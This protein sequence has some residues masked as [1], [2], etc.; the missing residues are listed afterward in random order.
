MKG[1]VLA[2]DLGERRI[3]LAV[4]DP[5]RLVARPL[6]TLARRDL[7]ADVAAIRRVAADEEVAEVVEFLDSL[8]RKVEEKKPEEKKPEEKKPEEKKPPA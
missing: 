2:L 6:L 8:D 3:G 4:S 5:L 1:R 7:A